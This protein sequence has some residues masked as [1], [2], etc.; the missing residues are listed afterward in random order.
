MK[1]RRNWVLARA[2]EVLE[3]Y[4]TSRTKEICVDPFRIAEEAGIEVR[5]FSDD[6][7]LSGFLLEVNGRA[8]IGFNMKEDPKRRRFTIAHELGHYFLHDRTEAFLDE[9]PGHFLMAAR[10]TRSSEGIDAREVE[11]NLFAAELLMPEA[12][13]RKQIDLLVNSGIPDWDAILKELSHSFKV[14]RT[15]I[16]IRLVRLGYIP[17]SMI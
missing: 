10:D 17:E 11:A 14:S 8:V 15:A 1:V 16:T 6:R 13:I 12:R 7:P 4:D 5:G 3:A 2:N 9:I